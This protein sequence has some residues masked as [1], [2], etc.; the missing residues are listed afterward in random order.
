MLSFS[1]EEEYTKCLFDVSKDAYRMEAIDSMLSLLE[2]SYRT[3]F[4]AKSPTIATE[5][6]GQEPWEDLMDV[7]ITVGWFI[8]MY[9]IAISSA[10]QPCD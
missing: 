10:K 1:L 3:V 6:H 7:S 2:A 5:E 8:I 9:P 4:N